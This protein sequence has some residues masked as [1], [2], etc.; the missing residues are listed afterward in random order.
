[1]A[2]V[3]ACVKTWAYLKNSRKEEFELRSDTLVK[4]LMTPR[5]NNRPFIAG[6]VIL[7]FL[8]IA[9]FTALRQSSSVRGVA[10]AEKA[11]HT[12]DKI[13]QSVQ[14]FNDRAKATFSGTSFVDT[15]VQNSVAFVSE[16]AQQRKDEAFL[17]L[18][19]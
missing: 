3:A 5:R 18:L 4:A 2:G 14:Q 1:M 11:H 19:A 16:A 7:C 13:N 6:A 9:L 17:R 10:E 8:L 15:A 12:A